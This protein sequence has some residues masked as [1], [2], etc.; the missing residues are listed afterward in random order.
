MSDLVKYLMDEKYYE[1]LYDLG[2]VVNGHVK[3]YQ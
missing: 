1:D 2:T 3:I